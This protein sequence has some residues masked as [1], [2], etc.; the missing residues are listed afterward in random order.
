M[1]KSHIKKKKLAK[2]N[3]KLKA[4]GRKLIG[5]SKRSMNKTILKLKKT[6]TNEE[7]KE[8]KKRVKNWFRSCEES[9]KNKKFIYRLKKVYDIWNKPK[10]SEGWRLWYTYYKRNVINSS[11]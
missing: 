1:K 3:A 6:Q 4:Q 9:H 2:L 8:S 11:N 7:L 10:D 5:P